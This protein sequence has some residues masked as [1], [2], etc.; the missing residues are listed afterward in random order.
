MLLDIYVARAYDT[1]VSHSD[2]QST[3][4]FANKSNNVRLTRSV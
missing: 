3:V 1:F 2:R 4:N